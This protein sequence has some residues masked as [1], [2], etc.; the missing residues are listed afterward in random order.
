MADA[1]KN[2]SNTA[3]E[4]QKG[5]GRPKGAT[6]KA[7]AAIKDMIVEALDKSGGVEYL[8][9]QASLNPTAFMTLVGKIIPTQANVEFEAGKRLS[10]IVREIVRPPHSNG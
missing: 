10:K 5:K 1:V 2:G 3:F 7:T 6:N 8:I 4:A 9:K